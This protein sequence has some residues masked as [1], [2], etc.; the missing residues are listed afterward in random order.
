MRRRSAL[1]A[2]VFAGFDQPPAEVH[3]PKPIGENAGRIVRVDAAGEARQYLTPAP[4]PGDLVGHAAAVT[5]ANVEDL[6]I[7]E[8]TGIMYWVSEGE[9][10]RATMPLGSL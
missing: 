2:E 7:D 8:L 6:A 5:L 3:L 9:I 1:G 10:W 4:V